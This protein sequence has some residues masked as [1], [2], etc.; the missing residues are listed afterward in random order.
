MQFLILINT[1]QEL[2]DALPPAEYDRLM[3]GCFEHADQL[4][5]E[6]VLL[7]SQQ[8][9]APSTGRSIRVRNGRTSVVD[10]P[11]AETKELLAG[12]NLIEA[13][14]LDEAEAIARTF[15]WAAVGCIE[16]RPVRDMGL[17]RA[18][19]GAQ[20]GSLELVQAG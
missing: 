15:P 1:D 9:E 14:D 19:V 17:V 2:V 6:G 3:R 4:K 7:G 8:L 10:G 16:V 11:F 13:A 12:F 20:A 18:R 5:R